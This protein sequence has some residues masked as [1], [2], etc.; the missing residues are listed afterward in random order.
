MMQTVANVLEPSSTVLNHAIPFSSINGSHSLS[1]PG[2]NKWRLQA[3]QGKGAPEAQL[4]EASRSCALAGENRGHAW[5]CA[6]D[7]L[8]CMPAGTRQYLA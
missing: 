1:L 2:T 4:E 8:V 7:V 5:V 6:R 3:R